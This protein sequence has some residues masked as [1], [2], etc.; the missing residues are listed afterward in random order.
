M[1][2]GLV[3]RG[4]FLSRREWQICQRGRQGREKPRGRAQLPE[5]RGMFCVADPVLRALGSGGD[6]AQKRLGDK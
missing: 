5:E 6:W 2:S 4:P 3:T 1:G